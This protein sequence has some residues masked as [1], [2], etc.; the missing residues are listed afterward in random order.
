[1]ALSIDSRAVLRAIADHLDAFPAIQGDLD[2]FARKALIKQIKHKETGLP[3]ARTIRGATGDKTIATILDGLT[4]NEMGA[5]LKKFDPD[6]PLLKAAD[7]KSTRV[8]ID[9]LLSGRAEPSPK[10]AKVTATRKT[11]TPRKPKPKIGDLL[12]SKV[13]AG[14]PRKKVPAGKPS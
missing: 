7:V 9:D 2:E 13:H 12:E 1:M 5:I 8:A 6:S 11:P 10:A 4:P 3:L 14:T